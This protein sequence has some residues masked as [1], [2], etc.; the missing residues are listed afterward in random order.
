MPGRASVAGARETRDLAER[1]TN[2][3]SE[4]EDAHARTQPEDVCKVVFVPRQGCR[5][6]L[7]GTPRREVWVRPHPYS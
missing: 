5:K 1:P 3:A 4:I 2:T 6:A 7:A